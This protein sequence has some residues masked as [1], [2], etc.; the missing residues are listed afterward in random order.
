MSLCKN[1]TA[2]RQ[3][4]Y[5]F[6]TLNPIYELDQMFSEPNAFFQLPLCQSLKAMRCAIANLLQAI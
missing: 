3:S 5:S 1:L 6:S 4:S 2:A